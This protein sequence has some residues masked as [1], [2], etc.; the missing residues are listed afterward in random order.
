MVAVPS[1]LK[2]LAAAGAA[3]TSD[4]P[5]VA[6]GS[7]RISCPNGTLMIAPGMVSVRLWNATPMKPLAGACALNRPA[8][9]QMLPGP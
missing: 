8:V 3:G 9:N 5:S 7:T 2:P 6:V 1:L 4:T